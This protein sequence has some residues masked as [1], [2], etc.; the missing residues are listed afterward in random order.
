MTIAS[1]FHTR[2]GGR[3][4]LMCL[5]IGV[6][7]AWLAPPAMSMDRDAWERSQMESK[8]P[9]R[10]DDYPWGEMDGVSQSQLDLVN[11]SRSDNSVTGGDEA[12]EAEPLPSLG[13]HITIAL[14]S[15]L[16]WKLL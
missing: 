11:T 10:M 14:R 1:P 5:L 7:L 9:E 15:L 12:N 4:V 8:I 13:Q 3:L 16:T 6:F 2:S